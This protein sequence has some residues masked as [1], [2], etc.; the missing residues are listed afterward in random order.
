M[1]KLERD[2]AVQLRMTMSKP[3]QNGFQQVRA[4]SKKVRKDLLSFNSEHIGRAENSYVAW[5]DLMGSGHVMS[6]STQKTANF[7][8]R[9]HMAVERAT[10]DT[11]FSGR[12][13]VV[14]DGVFI[15]SKS[16]YSLA[17]V[18]GRV[19]ILLSAS[20]IA[21]P[22][23]QDRCLVRA[24]ISFGPVY[25]GEQIKQGVSPK[26]FKEQI[27]ILDSVMFGPAIIQAYKVEPSAPPY[28]IAV[29]ESARSFSPEDSQPF[30]LTHWPWWAPNEKVSYPKSAPLT[31]LK[32][33]L[34]AELEAYF[35]W[36]EKTLI[37][38]GLDRTKI[39]HWS[40]VCS[41]YFAIA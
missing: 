34:A 32:E 12:L 39:S 16:K 35:G 38:H 5:I 21:T 3:E 24:G 25:F 27:K 2:Y 14:N 36:L 10:Q 15:V 4:Y 9:L 30:L 41:Q 29:H 37:Y 1:D 28:G 7:L 23:P 40:A 20:F 13:L 31:T 8:A 33:C 22:R 19:M 6:V 17:S 26:K 11:D 18:L